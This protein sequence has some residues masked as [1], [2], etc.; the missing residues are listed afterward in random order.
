MNPVK[1]RKAF[2]DYEILDTLEVGVVLE[3]HEVKSLKSGGGSLKDSH[4]IVK[5][6]ELWL[7]NAHI[8]RYKY[9]SGKEYDAVRTRKLLA[10]K[11]EIVSWTSKMKQGRLT[12]VPLKMYLKK[13]K[14][15]AEIGLVRGKKKH[16]KKEA[17]KKRELERELHREKRKF[18]I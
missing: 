6:G 17:I 8:S 18:V 4:V 11:S 1:N 13:G 7:L 2:F 15:K 12:I 9:M 16:E 10:K 3:G 14:I 5:D